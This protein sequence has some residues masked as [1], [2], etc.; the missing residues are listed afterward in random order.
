MSKWPYRTFGNFFDRV[1]RNDL[2]Q[3]FKDIESDFQEIKDD[4]NKVVD[5]VSDEAF[6]KVVGSAKLEWLPPVNTFD[7][8]STTYPNATEGKTVMTKDSGKI[9][10]F[11]D[12]VW[13]EI[14]EIDPSAINEVDARLTSELAEKATDLEQRAV[15]PRQPPFNVVLDG[16][17]EATKIQL[18]LDYLNSRGGGILLLPKGVYIAEGLVVYSNITIKGVHRESTVIKRP[19]RASTDTQKFI[20]YSKDKNIENFYLE[21][22]TIDGNYKNLGYVTDGVK[23]TIQDVMIRNDVSGYTIKNIKIKNCKFINGT[24]EAIGVHGTYINGDLCHD[25]QNIEVSDCLFKDIYGNAIFM[26]GKDIVINNN[27][28]YNVDDTGIGVDLSINTTIT[29]NILKYDPNHTG[30]KFYD[31]VLGIAASYYSQMESIVSDNHV[32]DYLIGI[33]ADPVH[34]TT[35]KGA[36]TS[37]I[38]GNIITSPNRTSADGLIHIRGASKTKVEGNIIDAYNKHGY[39]IT[40]IKSE[41]GVV[42]KEIDVV[43]NSIYNTLRSGIHCVDGIDIKI[44]QNT[45]V[46]CGKSGQAYPTASI[47]A[48]ANNDL[49]ISSNKVK[50]SNVN[51]IQVENS[52]RGLIS[53]NYLTQPI[54][55]I[56]SPTV[57]KKRNII[58]GNPT[59]NEGFST[60]SGTGSQTTFSIPHGL[61][62][63]PKGGV[64]TPCT[65]DAANHIYVSFDSTNINIVFKIAPVTGTNNLKFSWFVFS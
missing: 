16:T 57:Y 64:V 40:I 31:G 34:V 65:S 30:Y 36:K 10:R 4:F 53:N 35:D 5:T 33:K 18:A 60:F 6:N 12:L 48:L 2:N 23:P 54:N 17:N 27:K 52:T 25:V 26:W 47:F 41:D 3:N 62:V 9:Y 37:L 7:D 49:F 55:I 39:G 13:T 44:S 46:D 19:N 8:L 20:L 61:G 14:Q 1:F 59:E 45:L 56:N 50:N 22:V 58:A 51:S 42:P 15:N 28:F 38:K 43:N 63:Q 24:N 32:V 29:N 21:D 11:T